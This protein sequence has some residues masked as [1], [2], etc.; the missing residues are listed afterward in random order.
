MELH[1]SS[2]PNGPWK[3]LTPSPDMWDGAITRTRDGRTTGGASSAALFH[4][5]GNGTV[6][7]MLTPAIDRPLSHP[8]WD[9]APMEVWF[10]DHWKGPYHQ[11]A[12]MSFAPCDACSK[13]DCRT[14]AEYGGPGSSVAGEA[15]VLGNRGC[16]TIVC[17]ICLTHCCLYLHRCLSRQVT[18]GTLGMLGLLM[19]SV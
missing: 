10:A 4:P 12:N 5:S 15:R 8:V 2:S 17:S 9:A 19:V 13:R 18:T 1:Y 16:T 6:I 7:L 11:A 14:C 3:R